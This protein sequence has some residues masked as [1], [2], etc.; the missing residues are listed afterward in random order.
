MKKTFLLK[1]MLLLCALIAG[2]SSTWAQTA[3]VNDVLWTEPFK[4]TNTSTSFSAT[5]SWGDYINP[6]TFVAADKSSLVYSSSNAMISSTTSTNMTGAHVWLN[7]SVDGYIQVTGIKLY[8]ATKVKVSWAQATSGSSTTVYYQFDGSGDFKSL[9]TCSGPNENFESDELSVTDHTTIALKFFHP[10]S[11]AKNT[12]IDNLKLTVTAIAEVSGTTAAPTISGNTPFLD[13]TTV[14]ITNAASAAGANIYYTLNGDDPTTTTSATCFA[15]SAAF[16]IDETTTVKAI[17]KKST[18][19]NASSVVSKTFT[20]VTPITV[21]EALTAIDALADN[22]TSANQC[23]SGIVC[24]AGTLSSGAITYY[25]SADGTETN[26]LQVFKGKGLN[27]ADFEAAGDIAVGDEVVIY[28]TLKKFK[29]GSTITPEFDQGSY[30]LSKVRKAAPT[31]TLDP[32][33]KTLDAY[34]H[35][36]VDVT[37]TTNTDGVITCKSNNEDVATVALKS[38]GVYTITAQSEGTATITI[39]SAPSENYAAANASVAITVTD[40]RTAAGISYSEAT[41]TTAWGS[42]FEGQDLTNTNGVSVTY[43]STDE[44]VATVHPTTGVVTMLKVGTTT[45]KATFDGDATYKK[46]IASY[47]LT[48]NKASAGLSYAVNS[49]NIRLNDGSFVAPILS[50]PNSLSVTYAS[51][52]EEVAV[53]DENTG[54]LV[55]VETAVGTAKITASFAGNDYYYPGSANYTINIIDPDVKGCVFNPYTVAEVK[56]QATATTFGNGI[57]VTGYIVGNYNSTKPTNPATVDTNFALADT[58]DETDGSKTIPVELPNSGT[59]RDDWGPNSNN[60]IGYKVLLKGNAQAYF[61]VNGIKGT[62]EIT[63]V[64]IPL[65]P[66]KTYTTLT[67]KYALNFTSVSSDL[68]AF[69][70]LDDDA[71]DGYITM[72]EVEKVPANTGL[73]LKAT[74]T[75]TTVNVPVLS[76][77]AD[78]VTGNLMKGSA[79]ETTAIAANAGYILKDGVFQPALEGTLPAGKA[80]LNIAVSAGAPTLTLDFGGTTGINEVRGQ[81]EEVSGEFYNLAGQRVANPTKGLYIVNGR[82]VIIK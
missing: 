41:V 3:A 7:K 32:T 48:I 22:G 79:T 4:G 17:A 82:K 12:R 15:Y 55:Y 56:G 5:S 42:D 23:V 44:T 16:S 60:V 61:S 49:F 77:A 19:T 18:D 13:N 68:K 50:N 25:I 62:N 80:Y 33:S 66:T 35:E 37:L 9:S 74:K 45:I 63:A 26:R 43:S 34:S 58:F 51:N 31:F 30:L 40:N 20:K 24:T 59:I 53:V 46:A 57:Y 54:V 36:T 75:N 52:N 38:A 6:T 2:T 10:S 14:T 67:S 11:N 39:I 71:S 69:I 64:S 72:T 70:V 65:K 29:S 47:T 21:T 81:K 27:N 73:V 78:D 76:S 1:T 8:N 28:G